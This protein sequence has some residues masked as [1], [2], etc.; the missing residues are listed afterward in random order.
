MWSS[1]VASSGKRFW[2]NVPVAQVV[3][4]LQRMNHCIPRVYSSSLEQTLARFR[5]NGA[6]L[7]AR[8]ILEVAAASAALSVNRV[9]M[10][11]AA[12]EMPKQWV[13]WER[14]DW[15][16][17]L[18]NSVGANAFERFWMAGTYS[19]LSGVGV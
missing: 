11:E 16:D 15:T 14:K 7:Y 13:D 6:R 2:S 18:M 3:L 17:D 8:R 9:R 4:P 5:K 1:R 10:Q 19:I 12:K